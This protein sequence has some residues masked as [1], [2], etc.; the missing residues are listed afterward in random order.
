MRQSLE[1][2][3]AL[4]ERVNQLPVTFK[5]AM[6]LVRKLGERYLWVDSLCIVQD[7]ANDMQLQI[8]AMNMIY[9]SA[10][11][12]RAAASGDNAN[13]G[14]AGMSAGAR[15]FRQHIEKV[16]NVYLINC[17]AGFNRAVNGSLP[18]HPISSKLFKA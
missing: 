14:L 10:T 15:T 12:T 1:R 16:Q 18:L 5:D 2:D 11:L 6:S 13:S 3:G 17:T 7:D 9:S 4:L 8:A